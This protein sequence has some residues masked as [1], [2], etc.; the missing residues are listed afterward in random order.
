MPR[1][2]AGFFAFGLW[3]RYVQ[4]TVVWRRQ[5]LRHRSNDDAAENWRDYE[6][7]CAATLRK[8]GWRVQQVGRSGDQGGDLI[9]E[10]NGTRIVV[11]CKFWRKTVGNRAVQEAHAAARHYGTLHSVVV[12]EE[13]Y[14]A[15]ARE[16][17]T[18][19]GTFLVSQAELRGLS[20]RLRL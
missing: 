10:W 8:S 13:G 15:A 6:E 7:Y 9:A 1:G 4:R 17:A 11:Q 2:L 14:T 5:A 19:T 18:S 3:T 20:R 12:T 16:L